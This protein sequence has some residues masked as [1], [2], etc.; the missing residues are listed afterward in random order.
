MPPNLQMQAAITPG[1]SGPPAAFPE[2]P[3]FPEKMLRMIDRVDCLHPGGGPLGLGYVGGTM[4]V[5]P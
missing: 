4:D 5:D 2:G 1:A 3:P